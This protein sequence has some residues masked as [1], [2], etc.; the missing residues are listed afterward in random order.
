MNHDKFDVVQYRDAFD[1]M[2]ESQRPTLSR[3]IAFDDDDGDA[4]DASTQHMQ[5][6]S[7]LLAPIYKE[8]AADGTPTPELVGAI[9]AELP[10]HA[11]FSNLIPHGIDGIALV[12]KNSCNQSASFMVN[13]PEVEFW[14][15]GDLHNTDFDEYEVSGDFDAAF[16]SSKGCESFSIH[17]YPSDAI[18]NR[19][20]TNSPKV[21]TII[22]VLIFVGVSLLFILYDHLVEKRQE[23]IMSSA[24]RSSA[25]INSLFPANVRERLMDDAVQQ[26]Q[27][28][29]LLELGDHAISLQQEQPIQQKEEQK[30]NQSSPF[31][32]SPLGQR[33]LLKRRF[34]GDLIRP[35][36]VRSMNQAT[37][38]NNSKTSLIKIYDS[39][40][41]ADFF[42]KCSVMFGTI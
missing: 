3:F 33:P 23:K 27:Q 41:I 35:S 24:V 37:E 26:Q 4:D 21:Y 25:L 36:V 1:A 30:Q 42:P 22:V 16:A 2:V 9:S 14:G 15:S 17:I 11:F 13:G 28:Q 7:L 32:R 39:K 34:S 19:Y 5:P 10:W 18:M 20:Q 38:E 29:E 40:P 12:V 31:T 8:P 6:T